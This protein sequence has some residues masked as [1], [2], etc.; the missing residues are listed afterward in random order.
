VQ[1]GSKVHIQDKP[2][3]L[4]GVIGWLPSADPYCIPKTFSRVL[5]HDGVPR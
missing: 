2:L 3:R 4:L 5:E 1:N